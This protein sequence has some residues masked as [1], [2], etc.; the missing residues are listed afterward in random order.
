M[1]TSRLEAFSD[2]VL[3][4]AITLLVL[5]IHVPTDQGADLWHPLGPRAHTTQQGRAALPARA[6]RVGTVRLPGR[7]RAGVRQRLRQHRGLRPGRRRLHPRPLDLE[8]GFAVT[9]EPTGDRDRDETPFERADRNLLELL[10]ELRV[11]LPGVQ[12]LFAFLP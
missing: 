1:S 6:Q 11:A 4:I 12:V 9:A 7:D 2:G 8:E 3:A 5:E 10:N